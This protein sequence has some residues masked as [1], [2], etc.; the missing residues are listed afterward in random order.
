MKSG[1]T[2]FANWIKTQKILI[3]WIVFIM[4]M[5]YGIKI[6]NYNIS[7][8][9]DIMIY[10]AMGNLKAYIGSRRFA[11]S[12]TKMLL[13]TDIVNPF[14]L[15]FLMGSILLLAAIIWCYTLNILS[16]NTNSFSNCIFSGIFLTHPLM[17]EQ[18]EFTLQ[19]TE[20]ALA[21]LIMAPAVYFIYRYVIMNDKK[22]YLFAG[23]LLMVWCF[24]T[25]QSF[26]VI[27]ILGCISTII[28]SLSKKEQ[29]NLYWLKIIVYEVVILI[30]SAILY[31][32]VSSAVIFLFDSQHS[33][34]DSMIMWKTQPIKV[35][36]EKIWVFL[37]M[38]I[39]GEGTFYNKLY[40][41]FIF[42]FI[43]HYFQY[44]KSKS[45]NRIIYLICWIGI[46]V[47]PF[48][49]SIVLG[50][51]EPKRAQFYLPFML[52]LGF[53]Y[54]SLQITRKNLYIILC[55]VCLICSFK[56]AVITSRL[57]YTD[58]LRFEDDKNLVYSISQKM[59]EL[60][61][62]S[63]ER[64]YVVFIGEH[65][66]RLNNSAEYGQIIGMSRFNTGA[67]PTGVTPNAISIFRVFGYD[68]WPPGDEQYEKAIEWSKEMTCWPEDGSICC[69]D[70]IIVVKLSEIE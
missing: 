70:G 15:N 40:I 30:I 59:G 32:L 63:G 28:F 53:Y 17:A 23:I 6:F 68:F 50:N 9:T 69:R 29:N 51:Q 34:I 25:Y 38:V 48:M 66:A 33:Y 43:I 47:S 49:M 37:R 7:I 64:K 56:Q 55:S 67:P 3:I 60:G 8:D 14:L 65:R 42:L 10:N 13:S 4:L 31:F 46:C 5:A 2:S 16:G 12:F 11:V 62:L 35:C 20:V 52:A 39:L 26:F 36:L 54:L 44:A 21:L 24:G 18:F 22:I 1:H 19:G 45:T 27:Y 58:F 57:F 41:L 61:F